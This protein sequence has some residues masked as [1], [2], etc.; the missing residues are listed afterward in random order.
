MTDPAP[1]FITYLFFAGLWSTQHLFHFIK[2][3]SQ[4]QRLFIQSGFIVCQKIQLFPNTSQT[5]NNLPDFYLLYNSRK[6]TQRYNAANIIMPRHKASGRRSLNTSRNKA[7][8][9][10]TPGSTIP[11]NNHLADRVSLG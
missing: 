5:H 3:F 8:S 9:A 1:Y 10:G 7:K 11:G 4:L 2:R 6:L